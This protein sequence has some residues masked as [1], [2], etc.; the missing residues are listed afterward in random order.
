MCSLGSFL[1]IKRSA[2][3]IFALFYEY[4]PYFG[5]IPKHYH[6]ICYVPEFALLMDL[7]LFFIIEEK[8]KNMLPTD[9]CCLL[10]PDDAAYKYSRVLRK[11]HRCLQ[12]K[13]K[14]AVVGVCG[15]VAVL[16]MLLLVTPSWFGRGATSRRLSAENRRRILGPMIAAYYASD[17]EHAA[18]NVRRVF[19]HEDPML[20]EELIHEGYAHHSNDDKQSS[21]TTPTVDKYLRELEYVAARCL[22]DTAVEVDFGM[23]HTTHELKPLIE[24]AQ[25]ILRH[26]KLLVIRNAIPRDYIDQ[27]LNPKASMY[28][29]GLST[30]A[31]SH[32][33]HSTNGE[34]RFFSGR[35]HGRWEVLLPE[36]LV[37]ETRKEL[38]MNPSVL[39]ILSH[40][41]LLGDSMNLMSGGINV[42]SPGAVGQSWHE[43]ERYIFEEDS[44]D[45]L[46][47]AGHDIPSTAVTVSIPLLDVTPQHGPTEFCIG[48]STIQGLSANGFDREYVEEH[49]QDRSLVAKGSIYDRFVRHGNTACDSFFWKSPILRKGDILMFDYQLRHRGGLNQH[50]HDTRSILFFTY[51]RYWFKDSNFH[52]E[53]APGDYND[54]EWHIIQGAR[55]SVPDG[56]QE[57][58]ESKAR[59][60]DDIGDIRAIGPIEHFRREDVASA[61]EGSEQTFYVSNKDLGGNDLMLY[62]NEQRVGSLPSGKTIEVSKKVRRGTRFS[63]RKHDRVMYEFDAVN[64]GQIVFHSGMEM[65][66]VSK[67]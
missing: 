37:N 28:L 11:Y 7:L 21:S 16:L 35:D 10:S 54:F 40:K 30:G 64:E 17:P 52:Q 39:S 50:A 48:S 34:V 59:S 38:V 25:D 32:S 47:I 13:E 60:S 5:I 49:V 15:L 12:R 42:A 29:E 44:F 66:D 61:N 43:D 51:G 36:S 56:W 31:L 45:V 46:G 62:W 1:E 58:I 57:F 67:A 65:K 6:L 41:T 55:L 24:K 23:V 14:R 27:T 18:E 9:S 33:G 3:H 4:I 22:G 20:V 19:A 26:C 63:L 53:V 2:S 8:K